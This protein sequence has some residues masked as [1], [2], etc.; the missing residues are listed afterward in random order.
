MSSTSTVRPRPN[1]CAANGVNSIVADPLCPRNRVGVR[2][3]Q[4]VTR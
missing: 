4:T 1:Q 2:G 3:F